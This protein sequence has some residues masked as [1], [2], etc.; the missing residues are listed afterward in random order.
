[1]NTLDFGLPHKRERTFIVGFKE[2]IRF[3][4][5]KP[6]TYRKS[7]TEILEK[8]EEVD[9]RFYASKNIIISRKAKLKSLP[10]YPS[11]WHENKGG[12]ISPLTYSCALRAEASY[13]YLL[14]NGIRRFTPRE[15]LRLQGFPDNFK[16]V[17]P[18]TQIR[19]QVGN[20]VSIPV[21]EA[22]AKEMLNAIKKRE[23]VFSYEQLN[24]F[25]N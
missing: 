17:V 21:I 25:G 13:N 8:D 16:I 19:R 10:P 22:I 15:L 14:V 7:L 2:N 3:V 5:P 24:L 23:Q 12:N 18:Y 1:L 9:K 20:S 11:I 4:F 6:L